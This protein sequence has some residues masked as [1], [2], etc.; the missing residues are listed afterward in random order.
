M[1]DANRHIERAEKLVQKGKLEDAIQEYLVALQEEPNNDGIVELVAELYLRAGQPH[2]G[3][4]CFGY[5]FDKHLEGKDN[6]KAALIFR[7]MMKIGPQDPNRLLQFAKLIEKN[8]PEEA[9]THYQTAADQF[10]QRGEKLGLLEAIGRLANL[11]PNDADTQCLLAET[12]K[13]AGQ[14]EMAA[15]AYLRAA[16]AQMRLTA[17]RPGLEAALPLIERAHAV[18]PQDRAITARLAQ[19]LAATDAPKRAVELLKPLVATGASP[20]VQKAL[21]EA[22]LACGDLITAESALLPLAAAHADV[23]R[24]VVLLAKALLE[25]NESSEAADLLRRLKNILA[26]GGKLGEM[27]ALLQPIPETWQQ[28]APYLEFQVELFRELNQDQPQHQA[29]ARLFDLYFAEGDFFKAASC[30]ERL[31]DVD[32]YDQESG[33]RL[34]RLSGKIDPRRY[35]SVAARFQLSSISAPGAAKPLDTGAAATPAIPASDFTIPDIPLGPAHGPHPGEPAHGTWSEF[36][37][38]WGADSGAAPGEGAAG[39][40]AAPAG[41]ETNVLDDLMLQ[42]EIFLQ[43]GLKPKAL[44]RLERIAKVFPGEEANNERL[45]TLYAQ[46]GM[47]VKAKGAEARPAAAKPEDAEE[48]GVDMARVGEITRNIFR[49]GT[50]KNVLFSAVNDVGRA[51]RVSKCVAA[52]CVPG[53]TPTA[54]LE[55][56]ATGQKQSDALSLVKLV[57]GTLRLAPDGTPLA[58]EDAETSTKLGPLTQTVKGMGVRSL[59]ALPL[60]EDQQ[61]IGVLILEQADRRRVWHSNE[62]VVLKNIVDQMVLAVSH[63]KLRSLMKTL[64]VTD[65][66]TG[67]LTRSSYIDCLLSETTRVQKQGS[68]LCVVLMQFGGKQLLKEKGEEAVRKYMDEAGSTIAS[69]LRQNDVAVRYDATTLALVMPDTKAAEGVQVM[70]KM[71]KLVGTVKLA[72]RVPPLAWGMAE[73]VLNNGMDAVDSVTELINRAESALELALQEGGGTGKVLGAEA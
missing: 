57:Q 21:G 10:R 1:P 42:A 33:Q 19:A 49:Q 8:K 54:L 44:E 60:M 18:A 71:R 69:H 28:S 25:K 4:E 37:D 14:L 16:D 31:A 45:R 47:Q 53:K 55:Y 11:D 36:A 52:L 12:A 40:A 67:M 58:A 72:D 32:P 48:P 46:A 23:Q 68:T 66:R 61:P 2:K 13:D 65:E 3:Q 6:A 56:C 73:P 17:G 51:W 24:T 20:E 35:Q 62:V 30:L 26:Q 41:E 43:Y 38:R 27:Q 39:A 34:Q 7:K 9:A 64:S 5:L 29:L 22:A 50:V 63:V 15:A 70:E 59:L